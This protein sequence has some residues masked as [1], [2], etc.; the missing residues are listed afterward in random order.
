MEQ[1]LTPVEKRVSLSLLYDFYGELLKNGKRQI[2]ADYVL[3]DYSLAEIA[4]E[5][6]ITRQGVHDIVRRCTRQLEEYEE[7]LHLV[8]R[9]EEAK[10]T[11]RRI[12]ALTEAE[13]KPVQA[14]QEIRKLSE[15]LLELW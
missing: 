3:N 8:E 2:F 13:T 4:D 11:V 6:N 9:F 1:R 5:H 15:H 12:N 10:K 7:T 14:L